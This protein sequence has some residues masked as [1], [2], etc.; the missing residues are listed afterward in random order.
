MPFPAGQVVA[1]DE[2]LAAADVALVLEGD[3]NRHRRESLLQFA[4][5]GH[6]GFHPAD[7]HGRQGQDFVAFPDDPRGDAPA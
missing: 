7:L 6:D 3:A 4:V 2:H 1:V 5:V